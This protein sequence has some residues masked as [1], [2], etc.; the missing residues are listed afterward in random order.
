MEEVSQLGHVGSGNKLQRQKKVYLGP[1][2]KES[3][4][5]CGERGSGGMCGRAPWRKLPFTFILDVNI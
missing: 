5:T 4:N 2:R 3:R 1:R